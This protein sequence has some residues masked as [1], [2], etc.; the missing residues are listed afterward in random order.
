MPRAFRAFRV[1][2][3]EPY[4]IP[5][6]RPFSTPAVWAEAITSLC[7]AKIVFIDITNYT[8]ASMIL[9]G[10]RAV[11]RRGVTITFRGSGGELPWNIREIKPLLLSKGARGSEIVEKIAIAMAD[12]LRRI[13]TYALYADLPV[14][15]TN[16]RTSSAL[17]RGVGLSPML[18]LSTAP[19]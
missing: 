16:R 15:H 3:L 7:R 5:T 2:D 9:L 6:E 10:V 13:D 17:S 19:N 8:P 1:F 11:V 12:A 14:Y 4:F 18:L